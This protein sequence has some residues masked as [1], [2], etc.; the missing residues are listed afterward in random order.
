VSRGAATFREKNV[1]AP[2]LEN[3]LE[4]DTDPSAHALGYLDVAAPR[5]T[6]LRRVIREELKKRGAA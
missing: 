6:P 5:L 3:I 1:A 2:R 4:I